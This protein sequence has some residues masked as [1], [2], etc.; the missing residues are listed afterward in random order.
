MVNI[1]IFV[2][3]YLL[4]YMAACLLISLDLGFDHSYNSSDQCS[5][6]AKIKKS[7]CLK[8]QSNLC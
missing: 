6:I 3:F 5:N 8:V 7:I 4:K 2:K 1:Y